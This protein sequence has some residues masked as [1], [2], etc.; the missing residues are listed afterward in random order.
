MEEIE[1]NF[2]QFR[3]GFFLRGSRTPTP[4]SLPAQGLA[5]GSQGLGWRAEPVSAS[6]EPISP[7]DEAPFGGPASLEVPEPS[8]LPPAALSLPPSLP[9][10]PSLLPV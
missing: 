7:N 4:G 2:S 10:S 6:R 9:L 8:P 5:A 3:G 1:E